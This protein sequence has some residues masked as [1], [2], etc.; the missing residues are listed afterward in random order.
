MIDSCALLRRIV[1]A[2]SLATV[3]RPGPIAAAEPTWAEDRAALLNGVQVIESNPGSVPGPVLAYGPAFPI[4]SGEDG[5][6]RLP[7]VVGARWESGRVVAFGHGGF[8][9]TATLDGST[10]Q[11]GLFFTNAV[12]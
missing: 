1:I 3:A 6:R 9:A 2:I 11:T 10:T 7:V 12:R 8:F 4:V 5:G